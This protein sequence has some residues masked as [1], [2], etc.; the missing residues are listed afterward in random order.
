MHFD[1]P[2]TEPQPTGNLLVGQAPRDGAEDLQLTCRETA[3]LRPSLSARSLGAAERLAQLTKLSGRRLRK[4]PGAEPVGAA[5]GFARESNGG[6]M[7]PRCGA[8]HRRTELAL[9]A[10]A[11]QVPVLDHVDGALEL[12]G[13][14]RRIS[15]QTG[16]LA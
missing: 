2:G 3:M 14:L 1:G 5:T 12:L 10:L 15:T 7:P 13:R 8:G 16:N 6:L 4:R 9:D 11:R